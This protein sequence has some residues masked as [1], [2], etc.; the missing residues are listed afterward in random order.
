MFLKCTTRR[1]NGKEHRYWS[2]VESER[3][4]SGRVMQRQVL[5]LGEI[6]DMQHESWIRVIDIIESGKAKPRRMALFPSDRAV[7]SQ[8]AETVQVQ[9]DRLE[10]HRAR[11]WGGCW[12]ACELWDQLQLDKFWS[13]RLKPNRQGTRWL[14]VLK[15]VVVYRL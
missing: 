10:L 8:R 2:I 3:V 11:Q 13:S 12:L 14:N 15:V 7:S 6:N 5:Y 4:R 1:K 9:L